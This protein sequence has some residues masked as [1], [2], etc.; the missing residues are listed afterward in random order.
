[1]TSDKSDREWQKPFNTEIILPNE[2]SPPLNTHS[3]EFPMQCQ[4]H[5]WTNYV[6]KLTKKRRFKLKRISTFKSI[7]FYLHFL[8]LILFSF[9]KYL[10]A[11][12]STMKLSYFLSSSI[13]DWILWL[14]LKG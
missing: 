14:I 12:L 5:T 7:Y 9:N 6:E 10:L 1:M 11:V 4:K 8:F 3:L 2:L 13:F